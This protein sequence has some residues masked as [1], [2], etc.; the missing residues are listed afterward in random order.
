[1]QTRCS[2]H[3]DSARH[4]DVSMFCPETYAMRRGEASL[5]P[6][7]DA[8]KPCDSLKGRA[9]RRYRLKIAQG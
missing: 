9:S 1:V 7:F 2:S 4:I 8:M 3:L 6:L 5:G